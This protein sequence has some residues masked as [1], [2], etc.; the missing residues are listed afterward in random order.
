MYSQG[1]CNQKYGYFKTRDIEDKI[2]ELVPRKF[3]S[4]IMCAGRFQVFY[5][6]TV[7]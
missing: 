6:H 1:Y 4:N 5:L 2:K 7:S 3:E